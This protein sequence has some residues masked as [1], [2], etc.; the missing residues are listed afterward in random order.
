VLY[1]V[2]GVKTGSAKWDMFVPWGS[3]NFTVDSMSR[4]AREGV[5]HSFGDWTSEV[6]KNW[7]G[8]RRGLIAGFQQGLTRGAG[9]KGA[10]G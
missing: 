7:K 3:K 10:G 5:E 8:R 6:N 2:V 4:R 9:G 1:P